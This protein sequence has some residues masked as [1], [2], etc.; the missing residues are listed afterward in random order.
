MPSQAQNALIFKWFS[1][2][3]EISSSTRLLISVGVLLSFDEVPDANQRA[4][5]MEVAIFASLAAAVS[6][7]IETAITWYSILR[8][9]EIDWLVKEMT[10]SCFVGTRRYG[11][12]RL[13]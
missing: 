10:D 7:H 4:P 11:D 9:F 13:T 1:S 5:K 3:V 6:S 12:D 8:L 2:G